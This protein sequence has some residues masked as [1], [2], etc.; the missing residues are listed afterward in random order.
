MGYLDYDFIAGAQGL[1]D[2]AEAAVV[3]DAVLL[4]RVR[5]ARL[6]L[7]RATIIR[8]KNLTRD[9]EREG[10]DPE[11]FPLDRDAVAR[12]CRQTWLEQIEMRIPQGKR[13]AEIAKME[14]ELTRYA[15]LPVFVPLPEKFRDM[16]RGSVFDFTADMTRNWQGIVKV[17]KDPEAESGI[18]NRLE[19]PVETDT[20]YHR[21]EKYKLPMPWGL[22]QPSTKRSV[23]SSNIE[24]DDVP[25][26]GYHWYRLGTHRIGPSY[27][28]YF[29]WSWIIQLDIDNA[30][31][32]G[33]PDAEFEIWARI[34]F[35]GPAFP[36]GEAD[37]ENAICVERVVLAREQG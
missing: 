25:G 27:Y 26:P 3:G 10:S 36:H 14:T 9:W 21:L 22:Y 33:N 20:T 19:F 12:R 8:F 7:D 32:P 15:G 2:R 31:D 29:F 6:S 34:K 4:R 23:T 16:P 18:A 11:S 30:F 13:E 37:E 28:L 17:V 5:Q 1:F 24:P 35:E